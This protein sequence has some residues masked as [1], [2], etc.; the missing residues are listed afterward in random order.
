VSLRICY[1][2]DFEIS[3]IRVQDVLGPGELDRTSYPPGR[4]FQTKPALQILEE[5]IELTKAIPLPE[6]WIELVNH[7]YD[8]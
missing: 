4:K 5:R 7:R 6:W 3:V 8:V 2:G 1:A